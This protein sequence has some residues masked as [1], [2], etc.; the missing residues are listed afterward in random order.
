MD[1]DYR[2]GNAYVAGLT[3][4]DWADE[5]PSGKFFS[6][7][8]NVEEYVSGE[9]YKRELPCLLKL[10]AEHSLNPNI[11]VID[12]YV[13]LNENNKAGLGRYLFDVL[14]EKVSVIGVAKNPLKISNK[15]EAL[16][17]GESLKPLYISSEGISVI[18]AKKCINN[19]HGKYRFPSLLKLV[20]R[21]CREFD[22][23]E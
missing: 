4:S 12:G 21:L 18:N 6:K 5:I 13:Y 14:D 22:N 7:L 11:I 23:D 1:V 16:L 19:M 2:A 17:R 8:T 9:F 10:L 3:F 20:D 15:N